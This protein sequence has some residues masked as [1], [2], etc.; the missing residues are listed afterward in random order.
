VPREDLVTLN[1]KARIAGLV[2]LLLGVVAPLRLIYVPSALFVH[3]D[4]TATARNIA[5]HESLFR[6]GMLG[7]LA[8]G[9]ILVF[10]VLALYRLFEGVDRTQAVLMV[11]FGGV[12]PAS[13]DFVN[14]MNDAAALMLVRGADYLSVF[15]E[16]Q[17]HALALLFLR[18]HHQEVLAAE[19][20]WGLWL[21]P[22]AVLVLKSGFL[23]RFLGLWLLVNGFAYLAA[24]F[25]GLLAPQYEAVVSNVSFP[26]LLGEVALMLWLVIMG[27][28]PRA[29]SVS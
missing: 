8:S 26:A 12:I 25:A 11:A 28:K 5:A 14:V 4:A 9:V 23:P 1:K 16:P 10:V 24:S 18:V 3:G 17:R 7:D 13:I 29:A 27:A 22:L 2:Y 15:S 6:L 21:F 20:L 19:I